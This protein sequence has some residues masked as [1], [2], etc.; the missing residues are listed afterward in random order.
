MEQ[1]FDNQE[2]AIK[3]VND[4]ADKLVHQE[5][6]LTVM[7]HILERTGQFG[8]VSRSGDRNFGRC[9]VGRTE[10]TKLTRSAWRACPRDEVNSFGA[11]SLPPRL[12]LHRQRTRER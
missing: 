6:E 2:R 8:R 4:N 11:A 7:K 5:A 3:D 12:A 10:L 9:S 1:E